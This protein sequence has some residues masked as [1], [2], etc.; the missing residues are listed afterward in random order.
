MNYLDYLIVF[1]YLAAM[2]GF[3][4]ALRKQSN[5]NDYFLGG[6]SLG[7][8][9]L[10]LSTMA[11][12]LSAI[13][14]ISAPG[15]V[16]LREGG[17][18]K[19]LTYELAVPLA[20]IL[21]AFVI[22][23]PLYRSGVVSIYEFLE[24]RFDRTT[25]FYISV[26]F[27]V[28]RS[29]S[30]GI[31]VYATGIIIESVL[32][33]PFW[34]SILII[35]VITIIYS[36]QGGMKAVV[37]GD[38][39]QM[40]LIILGLILCVFYSVQALGGVESFLSG[41]DKERLVAV[42]FGSMGFNGDEFGFLPML[43]GGFVLYASYYGC[44]QTQAQRALSAR[45]LNDIKKILIANGLLRFPITIL[46]CFAGL[47]VGVLAL[48]SPEFLSK[49]PEGKPDFMMPVFIIEYLPNGLIGLLLV[50]ILAA[51]MSTLSSTINSLSAVS[52][53]DAQRLG[54]LKKGGNSEVLASR[55]IALFWG[56]LTLTLSIFA[57]N[58]APT[59]I[60]A[61]N[62]VGSALYGPI[63]GVFLFAILTKKVSSLSINIG[64]TAGL[65][66]NL[67]FW[68]AVK[69]V[70]WMWWNVIGFAV[71]CVATYLVHI[72]VS[73]RENFSE[74][75]LESMQDAVKSKEFFVGK[76][77]LTS[78]AVLVLFFAIILS[79]SIVIENIV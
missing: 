1:G 14:F 65:V 61:I 15:F 70:F 19:W 7:W 52:I 76:D 51:A 12:Q 47:S 24:R 17:G 67:I 79:I 35:C 40:I 53:E 73:G 3:G 49:I 77:I 64:L 44:D 33:V 16:G 27:Q 66:V 23:P 54:L 43:F 29:F 59:V 45:S 38:A 39:I 13:S 58:I 18:L 9:P 60:E 28:V 25:R 22:I 42:D 68:L 5:E 11:T 36:L 78:S 20:M 31:M 72:V 2:L 10:T 46:Y 50:A 8:A 71:M 6:N 26:S 62:K 41:I 21:V 4:Y 55:V 75:S 74:V 56:V 32:G 37:Y 63:L 34:Q 48:S 69:N 57:G 30:T